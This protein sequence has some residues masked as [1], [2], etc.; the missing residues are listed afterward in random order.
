MIDIFEFNQPKLM[1]WVL[2][3]QSQNRL[4][5]EWECEQ[6]KLEVI[7]KQTGEAIGIVWWFQN[8]WC[9]VSTGKNKG[10][11]QWAMFYVDNMTKNCGLLHSWSWYMAFCRYRLRVSNAGDVFSTVL[12]QKSRVDGSTFEGARVQLPFSHKLLKVLFNVEY[13]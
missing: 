12:L 10:F 11:A 7:T 3:K 5:I 9:R 1:S 4:A 6:P 8:Q 2:T 13:G